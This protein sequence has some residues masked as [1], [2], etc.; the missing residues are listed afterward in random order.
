MSFLIYLGSKCFAKF[1]LFYF[2]NNVC[3]L[4]VAFFTL[5][6]GGFSDYEEYTISV[7]LK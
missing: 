3:I 4:D 6:W 7:F 1:I 5:L 2:E